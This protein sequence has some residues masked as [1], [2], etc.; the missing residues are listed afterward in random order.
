M[1]RRTRNSR[2]THLDARS[3]PEHELRYRDGGD[4][5]L[6]RQVIP[7][8]H[9][10]RHFGPEVLDDDLLD[11]TVSPGSGA[12]GKHP[13]DPLRI[14]LADA[15][16]F[17]QRLGCLQRAHHTGDGAEHP[18]RDAALA[19]VEG[20]REQG[21]RGGEHEC[22]ADALR[23]ASEVEHQRGGGESAHGRGGGEHEEADSEQPPR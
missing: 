9:R 1:P 18:E 23:A 8:H 16:Q 7:T 14:G 22:S 15:E 6:E 19:P 4:I 20:L 2:L 21:E 12:N 10:G 5:F 17:L 13:L 3:R 11:V